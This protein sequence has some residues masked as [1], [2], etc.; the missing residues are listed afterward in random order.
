MIRTVRQFLIPVSFFALLIFASMTFAQNKIV[1]PFDNKTF[2]ANENGSLLYEKNIK[3]LF[4]GKK[5]KIEEEKKFD[6]PDKFAEFQKIIRTRE[7]E[8]KPNY[9][10]NYLMEELSKSQRMS[11]LYK[12]TTD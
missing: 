2:P 1:S 6:E 7:G 5:G 12:K 9:S 3:K 11:L 10:P 8:S 4:T